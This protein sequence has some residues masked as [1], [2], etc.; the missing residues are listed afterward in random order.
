MSGSRYADEVHSEYISDPLWPEEIPI[1]LRWK[2]RNHWKELDAVA[3]RLVS[4]QVK[5]FLW[6]SL[7]FPLLLLTA[8][9]VIH[10]TPYP[11][12]Q[13]LLLFLSAGCVV[14]TIGITVY[15]EYRGL[16][17]RAIFLYSEGEG[18]V[19]VLQKLHWR[20]RAKATMPDSQPA[21]EV[22]F[23]TAIV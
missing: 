11:I 14:L 6:L 20:L 10:G 19:F 7:A 8:L 23:E 9:G 13:Q 4:W 17:A 16:R 18:L 22:A 3:R 5:S 1:E 2:L 21:S 15:V 12:D